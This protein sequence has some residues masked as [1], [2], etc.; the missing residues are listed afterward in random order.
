MLGTTVALGLGSN[1]GNSLE[2]LR[3]ALSAIKQLH[4][5]AVLKVSSIY[6]SDA[7]TPDKA[8]AD[9]NRKFLNAVVMVEVA[10]EPDPVA[11]LKKFKKIESD[12]GRKAG[13]VWAPREIDI[14]IL[15]WSRDPFHS[16]ELTIPHLRL[17]ERPFAL[18]PLLEVWPEARKKLSV[19]DWAK[20]WAADLPYNTKISEMVWPRIVGILNITPDSFSD[21]G[22]WLNQEA[23]ETQLQKFLSHNVEVVDVGAESTRPGA[24]TVSPQEE[25]NRLTWIFDI[26]KSS[27]LNVSLDCRRGEVAEVITAKYKVD[28]LNDVS[29]F[30]SPLMQKLLKDS[31]KKAFVMHSLGIPPSKDKVLSQD[32]NPFH[33]LTTWWNSKR[34]QLFNLGVGDQ[35]IIFDPGI[36]F[37]KTAAQ[38]FFLLKHLEHFA[39]IKNE[40]MIGH[41]RKSFLSMLSKRPAAERDAETALVTQNLNQAFVQYLRV[42]DPESQVAALRSRGLLC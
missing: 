15:H 40:I 14:D 11:W 32:K 23:V 29:G 4:D 42:H 37:G 30:D 41:S 18:L 31:G 26:L 20:P 28:Y 1:L 6:E 24:A 39:E 12:I 5:V 38:S 36:G 22:Q 17:C 2:Y 19:P 10:G 3:S 34:E 16:A 21:G 13:E 8:P 33:E 7:L 35:Q 27:P 25:L 9:W